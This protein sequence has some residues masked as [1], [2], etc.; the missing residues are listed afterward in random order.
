[1]GV[2]AGSYVLSLA[3]AGRGYRFLETMGMIKAG[4]TRRI[5]KMIRD[6][7]VVIK[8]MLL[9]AKPSESQKRRNE[10]MIWQ[11]RFWEHVIRDERDFRNHCDYIHYDPVKHGFVET[12]VAW[13]YSTIHK[14]IEK[15]IYPADWGGKNEIQI[16]PQIG[17]E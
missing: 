12:P 3:I 16:S 17:R 15:E 2:V 5:H 4:F 1:M 13:Q 6:K 8:G 10:R 11:R 7:G 9:V 14:F